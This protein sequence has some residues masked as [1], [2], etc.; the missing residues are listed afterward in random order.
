M[1]VPVLVTEEAAVL[2][3]QKKWG[4]LSPFFPLLP[5]TF[6]VTHSCPAAPVY[7]TVEDVERTSHFIEVFFFSFIH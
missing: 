1:R 3:G 7:Q 4:K 5:E 2:L 6:Q